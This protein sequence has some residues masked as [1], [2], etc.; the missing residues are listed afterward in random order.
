MSGKNCGVLFWS[1]RCLRYPL[2]IAELPLF[3]WLTYLQ[4]YFGGWMDFPSGKSS[5]IES[6]AT[7][8]VLRRSASWASPSTTPGW[9]R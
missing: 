8:C 6:S 1:L 5:Y 2:R 4:S 7:V 3:F 9:D